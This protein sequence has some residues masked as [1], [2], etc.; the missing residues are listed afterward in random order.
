[1]S[2]ELI[3]VSGLTLKHSSGSPISGGKFKLESEPS[4][5]A[6]VDGAGIYFGPL[7]FSFSG[8]N[9]AGCASG[10]VAGGGSITGSAVRFLGGNE[11]ALVVGDGGELVATGTSPQ[12]ADVPVAGPVEIATA[13][14]S[15]LEAKT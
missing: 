5:A 4:A 6:F 13:G 11:P 10:T 3:A 2:W 1:M 9:A 8:G 14:Q 12:G 15:K 7:E